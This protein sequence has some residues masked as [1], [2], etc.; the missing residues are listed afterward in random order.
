MSRKSKG[1]DR[2]RRHPSVR[3]PNSNLKF[4]G[5]EMGKKLA[6][7]ELKFYYETA[8]KVTD[9]RFALNQ[10]NYAICSAIVVAVAAISGWA[11]SN[12]EFFAVG[13][14]LVILL[15]AMAVLFCSLWIGLI[16][17]YKKLNNAKFAVI[18]EMAPD[19]VFSS[20]AGDQRESFEPLKREWD[21]LSKTDAVQEVSSINIIAL[22][23]SN[24]E[25]LIPKAFRVL[26][27][28]IILLTIL[29]AVVNRK[30]FAD[31]LSLT[32]KQTQKVSE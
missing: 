28:V 5:D 6:F 18:N 32:I 23:S 24:I 14:V 10:W 7:E 19:V 4:W 3:H 21:M 1:I 17:D 8:D 15:S 25:Y 16:R 11:L 26:F 30:V 31:S 2:L 22:K 13:V 20:E 9:R 29:G 27:I 12:L